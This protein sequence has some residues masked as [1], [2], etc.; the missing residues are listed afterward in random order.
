MTWHVEIVA[1]DGRRVEHT[2]GP[3]ASE[4]LAE[5]ADAG[6]NRQLD[7]G[8]F[9]TRIVSRAGCREVVQPRKA[10]P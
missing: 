8:R 7:H 9:F 1:F 3:Y 2:I 6:L 10:K 4:R 5:R